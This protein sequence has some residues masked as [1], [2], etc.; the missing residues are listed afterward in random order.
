MVRGLL[1]ILFTIIADNTSTGAYFAI[2]EIG[3]IL[4]RPVQYQILLNTIAWFE[5]GLMFSTPK[6]RM[7]KFGITLLLFNSFIIA[8]FGMI[9]NFG[10]NMAWKDSFKGQTN[11]IFW[12]EYH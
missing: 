2:F 7:A 8:T 3:L 1:V 5:H 4:Q 12:Y 10:I 9:P 6:N 11:T